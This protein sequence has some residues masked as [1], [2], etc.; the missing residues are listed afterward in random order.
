MTKLEFI[1]KLEE[2]LSWLPKEEVEERLNFYS[3]MIDDRVEEGCSE[4]D[5]VSKIGTVEEISAQIIA[6]TPFVKIAKEKFIK[7]QTDKGIGLILLIAGSPIW[8]S[9]LIALFSVVI[10]LYAVLWSLVVSLWAVLVSLF[11][12][13]PSGLIAF[14]VFLFTGNGIAGL[15]YLGAGLVCSGLSLLLY[16]GCKSATK[17]SLILAK[18]VVLW[19]KKLIVR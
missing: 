18:S 6:D 9:L 7:N 5:A 8:L 11:V 13:G 3:E 15:A 12:C 2:K 19:I 4:E 16:F 17:G 1:K 14:I 10:S